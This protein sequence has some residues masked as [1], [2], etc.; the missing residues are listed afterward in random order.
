MR[1]WWCCAGWCSSAGDDTSAP[2]AP[3]TQTSKSSWPAVP[4]SRKKNDLRLEIIIHTIFL[5]VCHLSPFSSDKFRIL[6]NCCCDPGSYGQADSKRSTPPHPPYGQPFAIFF[7]LHFILDYDYM[8]SET[9]FKQEK[10]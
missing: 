1:W 5:I 6:G 9:D 10:K 3:S 2:G 7:C 8:C 4:H